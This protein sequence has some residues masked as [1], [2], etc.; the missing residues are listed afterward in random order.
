MAQFARPDSDVLTGNWTPT[1]LYEEINE[2]T[3]SDTDYI[4]SEDNPSNDLCE[5]G[6]SDLTD[7]VSSSGH[8]IRYRYQKGET[9]GG[10][11][12]NIDVT[13]RLLDGASE[14]WSVTHSDIAAGWVDGQATLSGGEADSIGDYTDLRIEFTA[15]MSA[16]ARTSWSEKSWAEFE[17]P[18]AVAGGPANLKT[19]DDLAK[20]SVKTV[21]ALTMASIK[22]IDGLA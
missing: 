4:R 6:L 12:A 8:I 1:P 20:A 11:P 10:Q 22:T 5:M 7:P 21:N 19:R 2:V 16:G 13:V 15:N 18:D 9:G 14:I 3:A 17:V